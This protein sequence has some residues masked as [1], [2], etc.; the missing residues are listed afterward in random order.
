MIIA[1]IINLLLKL[2]KKYRINNFENKLCKLVLAKQT[3]HRNT[4]QSKQSNIQNE[5]KKQF[6]STSKSMDY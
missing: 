4:T 2:V 3:H 6:D 5:K 1:A